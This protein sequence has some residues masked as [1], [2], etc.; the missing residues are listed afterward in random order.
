MTMVL[1]FAT[2]NVHKQTEIQALLGGAFQLRTLADIGCSEEIPEPFAT[3]AEN[4][5]AKAQYIWE[6][7]RIPTFADDS[8]LEVTALGGQPG[9]DSA[10]Y[11]GPQRSHADNIALLL[12]NLDGQPDRSARFVTII[13]LVMNGEYWQFEGS[14]AGTILSEKRGE[15]GF[16]Y[17]PV[18]VPEGETRTFAEMSLA[19]KSSMSH[20]ARAFTKLAEFLQSR[21]E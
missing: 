16:G 9:V 6:Q 11:A 2:N 1:C 21:I 19:E 3:I 13:T 20:R 14:I 5:R 4:S 10:H 12:K 7:Y 18:F 17:D 15:G 8:G